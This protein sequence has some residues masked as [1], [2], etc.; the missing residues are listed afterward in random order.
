MGEWEQ[1]HLL[2][3]NE[4]AQIMAIATEFEI[5][6][7]RDVLDENRRRSLLHG[8]PGN[9]WIHTNS[10]GTI[11]T[12]GVAES[13]SQGLS[14]EIAGGGF[15]A[16]LNDALRETAGNDVNWWIRDDKLPSCEF[17]V[18]R[19]LRY[20][21]S[22]DVHVSLPESPYVL[23][24][25]VSGHD[26]DR[27]LLAN[28]RA[29]ADHPEQGAWDR[30]TLSLRLQE[31]WFDPSGFLLLCDDDVIVASCW[32]KIHDLPQARVGEIYVIFVSP[33]FQGR[34]IGDHMLRY[35]LDSIHARGVHRASLFVEDS[36]E[37][38]IRLYESYGFTTTRIDRLVRITR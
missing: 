35:G 3:P 9:Y 4:R 15:D 8:A 18:L 31:H 1:R 32:T 34:G 14:I 27:W 20:M 16:S 2:S 6:H 29:F 12:F 19:H 17:E 7:G 21:E 13:S 38:A 23:R 33:D 28:N 24:T 36:N 30:T 37:G 22:G 5:S 10:D 26:D 11:V 25:F